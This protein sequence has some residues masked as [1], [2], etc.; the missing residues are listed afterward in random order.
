LNDNPYAAPRSSPSSGRRL[1]QGSDGIWRDGALLFVER[2]ASLPPRCVRCNAAAEV[3]LPRKLYWHSPW[4]A[5]TILLGILTYAIIALI[6]RKKIELEIGLCAEHASAR[7][8]AIAIA[9]ASVL[10]TI[11]LCFVVPGPYGG[12]MFLLFLVVLLTAWIV[13]QKR[14]SVLT[15]VRIDDRVASLRGAG[16]AFLDSLQRK[17]A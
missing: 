9:W 14:A 16:D 1:E 4:Y 6:V 8:K 15:P 12:L 3:H 11:A 10:A 5:L 2:G 7:R 17:A 13:G